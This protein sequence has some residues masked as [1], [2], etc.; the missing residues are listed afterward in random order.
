MNTLGRLFGTLLHLDMTS[1]PPWG[2]K[3]WNPDSAAFEALGIVGATG[4]TGPAGPAGTIGS[5]LVLT[6]NPYNFV[7]DS[8]AENGQPVDFITTAQGDVI[9]VGGM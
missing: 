9:S 7:D 6:P 5:L 8:T 4:A 2:V 3:L 1:G